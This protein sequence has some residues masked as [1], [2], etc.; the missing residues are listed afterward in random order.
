MRFVWW[1]AFIVAAVVLILF[2]VSNREAVAVR[3]WPLSDVIEMPLYLVLLGSLLVGFVVGEIVAWVAGLHWRHE[4]R[5][6][7]DRIAELERELAAARP[8]IAP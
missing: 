7:R 6:S 4:A 1:A 5:R 3:L 2:A 8:R